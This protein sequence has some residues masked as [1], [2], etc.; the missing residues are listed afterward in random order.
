MLAE[1]A[2]LALVKHLRFHGHRRWRDCFEVRRR[3]LKVLCVFVSDASVVLFTGST[4]LYYSVRQDA[5]RT[6]TWRRAIELGQSIIQAEALLKACSELGM[7]RGL[8][9]TQDQSQVS[10]LVAS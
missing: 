4:N 10:N 3:H 8:F 6:K 1:L 9:S 7:Y 2:L 5:D